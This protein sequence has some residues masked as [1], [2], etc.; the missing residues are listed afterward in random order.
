MNDVNEIQRR[1]KL[2]VKDMEE[3]HLNCR[4]TVRI[5]LWDDG[6]SLV[7]CRHTRIIE[8]EIIICNSQYYNDELKYSEHLLD[9]KKLKIRIDGRGNEYNIKSK[10]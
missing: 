3:R 8:D 1:I 4:H 2:V 10:S 5:L 6:T 9:S 7:E